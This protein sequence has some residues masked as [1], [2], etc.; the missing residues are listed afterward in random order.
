MATIILLLY[1]HVQ[2]YP[3]L[4]KK[5]LF[6]KQIWIF[7]NGINLFNTLKISLIFRNSLKNYIFI[8]RKD[9]CFCDKNFPAA[10]KCI[11][12]WKF[13]FL[14]FIFNFNSSFLRIFFVVIFHI[15]VRTIFLW[16]KEHHFKSLCFSFFPVKIW[17]LVEAW[18]SFQTQLNY[19]PQFKHNYM[20]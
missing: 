7:E 20:S 5:F 4:L 11:K 14:I 15:P 18:K 16:Y 1:E 6:S 10:A 8:N 13:S 2:I 19:R 9:W 12:K 3:C 17:K